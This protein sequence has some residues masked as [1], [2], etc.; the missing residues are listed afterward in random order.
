MKIVDIEDERLVG[1]FKRCRQVRDIKVARLL[2][3]RKKQR[4]K[5][6]D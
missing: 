4:L 5:V 2:K 1:H 3:K 6:G